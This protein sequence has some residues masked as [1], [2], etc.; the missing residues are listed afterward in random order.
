[1]IVTIHGT[2][3]CWRCKQI[4]EL[5]KRANIEFA[6]VVDKPR[7]DREYPYVLMELDYEEASR[8]A[9]LGVL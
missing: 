4:K 7:L 3:F 8:L 2:K 6:Y 9:Q 5:M 1:M